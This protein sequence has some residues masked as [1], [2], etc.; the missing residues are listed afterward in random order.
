M[1]GWHFNTIL[2]VQ[3]QD[4]MLAVIEVTNNFACIYGPSI[5]VKE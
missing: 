3:I 2:T 5:Y 4:N 1:N